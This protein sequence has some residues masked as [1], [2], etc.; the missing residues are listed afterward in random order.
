MKKMIYLLV[1]V[2]M[3]TSNL[4][5]GASASEELLSSANSLKDIL[6]VSQIPAN[7]LLKAR[8]IVVVPSATKVGFFVGGEFGEGVASIRKGD[9]SWSNPFF[10]KLQSGSLGWQFGYENNSIL[11]VFNSQKIVN[12]LLNRS[13]TMGVDASIS[14]GPLGKTFEKNSKIDLSAEIFAYRK[15]EGLFLGVSLKGA[16]INQDRDKNV[17][18]YGN[19]IRAIDIVSMPIKQDS[20]AMKQFFD[21]I[22]MI[23]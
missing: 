17:E 13:I 2:L 21:A 16:V 20:Y 9:G 19:G 4:F 18:Y 6:R 10:I 15:S 3:F 7:V 8:A 5:A 22:D 12:S 23:R 11:L 1:F 14:A